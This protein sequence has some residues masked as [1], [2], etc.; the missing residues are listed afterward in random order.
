[1]QLDGGLEELQEGDAGHNA[2]D[3]GDDDDEESDDSDEGSKSEEDDMLEPDTSTG[4]GGCA[5]NTT[6]TLFTGG[7]LRFLAICAQTP[8]P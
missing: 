3:D 6:F 8:R 1:M 5:V 7:C 4:E 2:G